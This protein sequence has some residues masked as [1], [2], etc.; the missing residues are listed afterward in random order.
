M[1]D[2]AKVAVYCDSYLTS[3]AANDLAASVF[4]TV[5]VPFHEAGDEM[6]RQNIQRLGGKNVLFSIRKRVDG[7]ALERAIRY[8]DA[9]GV[10]VDLGSSVL[11]VADLLAATGKLV[12]ASPSAQPDLWVEV[13]QAAR[14]RMSWWNLQLYNGADY[15]VWVRAIVE[16]GIMTGERAQSFVVPGYKLTWSTPDSVA[17]DLQGLKDYAPAVD[18]VFLRS[19][20][21]MK[22]R[23]AEWAK[24]IGAGL[25]EPRT[26]LAS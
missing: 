17:L 14:V 25:G 8:Y 4:G 5:V 21:Q 1:A 12:V 2:P 20:E 10:E 15:G 3:S 6:L 24:A 26:I 22:P 7:A 16:S 18:G 11:E 19:Y 9:D 13:L 23:A